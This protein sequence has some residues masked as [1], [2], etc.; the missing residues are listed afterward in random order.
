MYYTYTFF[1]LFFQSKS[2]SRKGTLAPRE[3]WASTGLYQYGEGSGADEEGK[4]S[5]VTK[6]VVV[7]QTVF[8]GHYGLGN[9]CGLKDWFSLPLK[10][11]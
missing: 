2:P 4:D 3:A 1:I 9:Q 10:S 6:F 5:F 7:C 8:E 11:K